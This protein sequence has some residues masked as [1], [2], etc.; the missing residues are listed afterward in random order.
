MVVAS[1]RLSMSENQSGAEMES[2]THRDHEVDV[3]VL[4]SAADLGENS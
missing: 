2:A 1:K 4:G 3:L